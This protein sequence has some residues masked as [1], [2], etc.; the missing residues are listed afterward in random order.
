MAMILQRARVSACQLPGLK[1]RKIRV[2]E[3]EVPRKKGVI[4]RGGL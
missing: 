3:G 4:L 2:F 1:E